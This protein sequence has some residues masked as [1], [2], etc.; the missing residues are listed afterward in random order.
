M[1]LPAMHW[2]FVPVNVKNRIGPELSLRGPKGAVAISQYTAESQAGSGENVT[3]FPRLPRRFAPR[4]DKPVCLTPPN[5]YCNT[6]DC[7]WRSLSAATD[8]IG[9][10][11]FTLTS[12]GRKC[13]PE[14]A[15]GAKR[16]RNDKSGSLAPLNLCRLIC[17]RPWRSMSAA[18]NMVFRHAKGA[19][20][21]C[22]APG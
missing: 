1:P 6:C 2:R 21:I 5:Y 7:L 22:S 8:A 4:N 20:R 13:L 15:T 10:Y 16:P 17:D 9:A 11:H 19:L 12:M 3:A 18:A 14:I